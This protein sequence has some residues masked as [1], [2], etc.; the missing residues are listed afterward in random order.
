MKLVTF[1]YQNQARLGALL[2][3]RRVADLNRV[4]P[5]LLSDMIG[6]LNAG[7]ATLDLARTA[8]VA[9]PPAAVFDL[10]VVRLKAPVPCPGKIICIGQNY[11]E[12]AKE[13]NASAPPFPIIFAKFDNCKFPLI[14]RLPHGRGNDNRLAGA[15][16]RVSKF[17]EDNG[18]R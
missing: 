15:D 11:L 7:E 1:V 10:A 3:G 18:E 13:S 16:D 9:V 5:R 12:H 17:G 2:P 4:D 8:L 14:V 6:F